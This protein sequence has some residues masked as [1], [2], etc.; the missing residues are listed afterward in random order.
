M[1]HPGVARYR[2]YGELKI[3][4]RII[5][6]VVAVAVV[7]AA[8]SYSAS[9]KVY[10]RRSNDVQSIITR[11]VFDLHI[12]SLSGAPGLKIDPADAL[13][14]NGACLNAIADFNGAKM[15]ASLFRNGPDLVGSACRDIGAGFAE[16]RLTYEAVRGIVKN[17]K[18][19]L[20]AM[21]KDE[22]RIE[23]MVAMKALSGE[24]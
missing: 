5:F 14:L 20:D 19:D 12:T 7:A 24:K 9:E 3:F 4:T 6:F 11:F 1:R 2:S 21:L 22:Q 10:V 15:P 23:A 17:L 16:G 13:N 8:I 18:A